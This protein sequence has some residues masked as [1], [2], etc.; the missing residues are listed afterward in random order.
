MSRRSES[1]EVRSLRQTAQGLPRL[2]GFV[3]GRLEANIFL[4][5]SAGIAMAP[6]PSIGCAQRIVSAGEPRIGLEDCPMKM[7]GVVEPALLEVHLAQAAQ[8][9]RV[10]RIQAER[11]VELDDRRVEMSSA[12]ESGGAAQVFARLGSAQGRG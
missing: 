8:R 6:S 12:A 7:D 11:S 4:Q 5:V 10:V 3:T 2:P 1:S 9:H